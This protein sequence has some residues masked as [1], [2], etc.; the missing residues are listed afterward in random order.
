MAYCVRDLLKKHGALD[1]KECVGDDLRPQMPDAPGMEGMKPWNF[2]DMLKL[3]DDETAVFS[4][5]VFRDRAHRD[6]VNAKVMSDP[7][8][9]DPANKNQPMPF[10]VTKM[11]YGGFT[12]I[13]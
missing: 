13:V 11:A 5:I 6:E 9:N 3:K 10:D 8:M 4:Y 12:A 1:Y 7:S 2:P